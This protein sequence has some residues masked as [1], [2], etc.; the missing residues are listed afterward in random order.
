MYVKMQTVW[1]QIRL[2]LWVQSDLGST[3]FEEEAPKTFHWTTK[4]D[5][6]CLTILQGILEAL[7]ERISQ[8]IQPERGFYVA[9]GHGK[10]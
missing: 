7:N 2:R 5:D 8:G 1:I 10:V 9:F 6:K 3:L 4:A